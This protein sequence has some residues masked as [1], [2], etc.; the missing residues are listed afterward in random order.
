MLQ[1]SVVNPKLAIRDSVKKRDELC[2][3][4]EK[5]I[6]VMAFKGT[7]V[8]SEQCRKFLRGEAD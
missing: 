4:C 6:E 3:V 1:Q 5:K 8:C 7:D 2:V